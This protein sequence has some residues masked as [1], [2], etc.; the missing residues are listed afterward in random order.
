MFCFRV[1]V[2]L[3]I[4]EVNLAKKKQKNRNLSLRAPAACVS[5]RDHMLKYSWDACFLFSFFLPPP[6]PF[7]IR[8]KE[9]TRDFQNKNIKTEQVFFLLEGFC[10]LFF[11]HTYDALEAG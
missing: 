4:E 9:S 7:P 10:L 11:F 2:F 1:V 8:N 5:R 6:P 3:Y